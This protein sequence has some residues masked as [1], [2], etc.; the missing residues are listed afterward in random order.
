VDNKQKLSPKSFLNLLHSLRLDW[1]RSDRLMAHTAEEVARHHPGLDN[2]TLAMFLDLSVL[3]FKDRYRNKYF[4]QSLDLIQ[5][6]SDRTEEEDF[7]GLKVLSLKV[8]KQ[9]SVIS[10]YTNLLDLK[11]YF[12]A[13]TE[14]FEEIQHYERLSVSEL[15]GKYPEFQ[16]FYEGLFEAYETL[17]HGIELV[18]VAELICSVFIIAEMN[19]EK[20][21]A[22]IRDARLRLKKHISLG[23]KCHLMYKMEESCKKIQDAKLRELFLK[24]LT[25]KVELKSNIEN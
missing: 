19:S 10:Q 7:E 18:D 6:A 20:S 21:R 5:P 17:K 16:L 24:N 3:Y 12:S 13:S 8:I 14:L 1:T 22:F 23:Q 15:L 25:G 9:A 4:K 11:M 2:P